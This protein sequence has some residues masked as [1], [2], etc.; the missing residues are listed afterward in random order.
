MSEFTKAEQ[1]AIADILW[2]LRSERHRID[3]E[4][5]HEAA[6]K[7]IAD[8]LRAIGLGEVADAYESIE[9]WFT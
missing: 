9:K 1:A 4:A 5:A 8:L 3:T 2:K 6:D 7:L